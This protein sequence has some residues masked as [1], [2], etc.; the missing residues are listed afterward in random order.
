[1]GLGPR[2][3]D[4]L[5]LSEFRLLI[6]SWNELHGSDEDEAAPP[7]SDD[8]YFEMLEMIGHG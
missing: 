1:M 6:R 7:P 5:T 3:A 2:E 4:D 8:D